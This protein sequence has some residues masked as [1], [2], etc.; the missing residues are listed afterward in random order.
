MTG[1]Y[2]YIAMLLNNSVLALGTRQGSFYPDKNFGS[3]ISLSQKEPEILAYARQAVY[4]I[5][6]VNIKS[7]SKNDRGITFY[8]ILNNEER[9]VDVCYD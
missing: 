4:G 9:Q 2:D 6:G 1:D 3:R 5:D 8:L 7:V